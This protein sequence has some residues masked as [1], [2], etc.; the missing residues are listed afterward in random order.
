[1]CG[2]AGV[3]SK[4]A[5]DQQAASRMVSGILHRGPDANGIYVDKTGTVALAHTRLSIIDLST[6]ANQPFHSGDQRYVVV[7]NGEIYNFQQIR[8]E[9]STR[10]S[11]SFKTHSDTEVIAEAFA[12]WKEKMVDRLE[13]MFAI[14]IFDQQEH[15][16]YLFRDRA[17]KK[18]LFYFQSDGIFAFSSE[19]KSLLQYPVIGS[20]VEIN[21]DVIATFLH[22]GYIPEP[23]T[24][25]RNI[26]KFPAAH[27]AVIKDDLGLNIKSYWN[28]QENIQ[29]G[30]IKSPEEARQQL[31]MLLD[32]AVQERLISDVP[33]GTF[34]SG[35]TDSSLV[36][37]V[38]SKHTSGK[39]K[40]FSIGFQE[41]KFDESKYARDVA[42]RLGTNHTEYIL[43]ERESIDILEVYLQHY[44]EPFADT[45]AIPTMLVSKLARKEVKV[46]LTGDGG[47]ELFQGYGSYTWANRLAN[48]FM[49]IM[50]QPLKIAL[51]ISGKSRL[52]RI[53]QLLE[54]VKIGSIRSHIFSQEQYFFSQHEIR[55][56]LLKDK[57]IFKP[58]VYTDSSLHA[59]KLTAGEQ[60]ALFDFQYYL[61]DDLLVKVDRASMYYAL[62]CRC[63]LLDHRI[64]EFAFSLH[65]SLKTRDG[66]TKWLLKE[67]LR[68]YIPD[69]LIDRPKWGF[70]VPLANWLKNDLRYLVD[71]YLSD[72]TIESI[73]LF[74]V[75]YIRKIVTEFYAGKDYLYNRMWVLI[76]LHKWL[77]E[78][79]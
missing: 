31:T 56:L 74:Q 55:D 24:V 7:F 33:L 26:F 44:D 23:A 17:G 6:G 1:M 45:S 32:K 42:S 35:G 77:K 68:D 46:I 50:Q 16:L 12:I 25:Y 75:S 62:E 43:T 64:V 48:P 69:E 28:L 21:L 34:L 36:S 38:A 63:P 49:Q 70:S 22:L 67:M 71:S 8:E 29:P 27:Y 20:K 39:L 4:T 66:K 30:E 72:E 11:V 40:T 53:A 9:L 2:I 14:A 52:E 13:G 60:Q 41:S 76:V 3:V 15:K 61:K 65:S 59:G 5:I 78:N 47:D 54:P 37:A 51:Q 79:Q 58:F 73:G 10:Y 19:I 57:S 18:P